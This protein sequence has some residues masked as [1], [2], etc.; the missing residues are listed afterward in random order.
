MNASTIIPTIQSNFSQ[1]PSSLALNQTDSPSENSAEFSQNPTT[2]TSSENVTL[3]P[4]VV[5]D[6]PC[7]SSM[8]IEQ[9]PSGAPSQSAEPT[10][11]DDDC[12]C[13]T[14]SPTVALEDQTWIPTTKSSTSIP[15]QEVPSEF[16]SNTAEE[17]SLPSCS[18][19]FPS[20]APVHAPYTGFPT[21]KTLPSSS[22]MRKLNLTRCHVPHIDW[23]SDGWCDSE[24]GLGN[25]IGY[26]TPECAYDG[27][28]CCESTCISGELHVCGVVKYACKDPKENLN[29]EDLSHME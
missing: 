18:P 24:D 27:G 25:D 26:N 2:S 22:P 29:V 13:D 1:P 3:K 15:I 23:V 16:P 7:P 11:F 6:S 19:L 17:G 9:L 20:L 8:P 14:E 28:D 12:A 21:Y 5:F 4:I 10:C